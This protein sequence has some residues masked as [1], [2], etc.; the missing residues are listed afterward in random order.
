MS[1][2]FAVAA[3]VAVAAIVA[4]VVTVRRG[5]A[6][7]AAGRAQADQL[8]QLEARLRAA[9]QARAD[10]EQRLQQDEVALGAAVERADVSERRADVSER[11][12][13][14]SERRATDAEGR[15]AAADTLWELERVRLE[16]EWRE[17]T[18]IPAP[19][20]EPWDGSIRA[21]LAVE[22]EI[23]REVIGVPTVLESPAP[24]PDAGADPAANG[25]PRPADPAG[26]T[27]P[28]VALGVARLT[29]E[30]LRALAR[31]GEEVAVSVEPDDTV[32]V[33][34]AIEAG[35]PA[36]DLGTLAAAAAAL[37]CDLDV[38]PV[39]GGL[40]ARLHPTGQPATAERPLR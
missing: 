38:R 2:A 1:A 7:R 20:P 36:P 11:R 39:A 4:L 33:R 31:V 13:D 12:A 3:V 32:T 14:V 21:A 40:E 30:M 37:G 8:D 34:V 26:S 27:D 35:G 24:G 10:A 28:V 23:I 16:R 25:T 18:G 6:A 17:V 5:S 19:L 22:L 29:G 15:L 9:D